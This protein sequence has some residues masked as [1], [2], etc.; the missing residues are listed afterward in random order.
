M[1][2][3]VWTM[4][5]T[6]V[7]GAS[8]TEVPKDTCSSLEGSNRLQVPLKMTDKSSECGKLFGDN[9]C[10][11]DETAKNIE[12][13]NNTFN[14]FVRRVI[15]QPASHEKCDDV[16][17][18]LACLFE[19]SPKLKNVNST[20]EIPLCK[21]T[22][23]LLYGACKDALTC[24]G[25]WGTAMNNKTFDCENHRDNKS[26]YEKDLLREK[27]KSAE[28]F[29]TKL[30]ESQYINVTTSEVECFN[31]KTGKYLEPKEL[32]M[33]YIFFGYVGMTVV[34]IVVC[35]AMLY[36]VRYVMKRNR[37]MRGI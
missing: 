31:L 3:S 22:C 24:T 32:E 20:R 12:K 29:C 35:L 7:I 15:I 33:S 4:F 34:A 21:S 10:C 8:S 28:E 14:N 11:S 23:E 27:V 26:P 17:E 2:F 25:D 1:N 9:S 16:F 37:L 30:R 18:H 19:C 13:E 36:A 5:V 6:M